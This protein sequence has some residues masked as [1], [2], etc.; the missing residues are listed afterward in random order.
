MSVTIW[1]RLRVDRIGIIVVIPSPDLFKHVYGQLFSIEEM[2][3]ELLPAGRIFVRE[4]GYTT[5]LDY[6]PA[7]THKK[8]GR[9]KIVD[10]TVSG[11]KAKG[12]TNLSKYLKLMLYP[13]QFHAGEFE[14]FKS[15]FDK[16]MG[17]ISYSGLYHMGKVTYLE[18]A[19]DSLTH[20]QHSFL[21]YRKYVKESD[22]WQE[23]DGHL[24][25]TVVG[26]LSSK[27]YFRTYD[28]HKQLL[29]TGKAPHTKL[30]PHTRIEAVLR[31]LGVA[32]V[33][34]IHMKNPFTK[35][36]IADLEM[37]LAANN[38]KDWQDFIVESLIVGVP[39]ALSN[40]PTTRK[41]H[42]ARLDTLP[43]PWWQP[44]AIWLDLPTALA[45]IA[46]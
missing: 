32:P 28:K 33:E 22:I 4:K 2:Q 26:S 1:R 43:V 46:P 21:P 30:L 44:E 10:I 15:V 25:S 17:D 38:E 6:Y 18:L 9:R 34:L 7:Y 37:A 5:R 40:H 3:A 35:L 41:K 45:V 12:K 16:L 36:L 27:F 23:K 29:D 14:H 19:V 13:S 11:Y 39:K 8:A 24:G 42:L 20:K 31:R